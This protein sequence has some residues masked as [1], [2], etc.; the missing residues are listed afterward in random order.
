[1]QLPLDLIPAEIISQYNLHQIENNGWI[2][3]EI[4]KRMYDLPQVGI[5]ANELLTQWLATRDFY[6]YQFTPGLWWYVWQL[7]TF[8]L[9]VDDFGI[10]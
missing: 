9:I 3:M 6:R 2:C 10:K 7:I 5:L 8:V 4:Q 1:M